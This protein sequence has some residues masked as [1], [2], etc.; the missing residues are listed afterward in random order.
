MRRALLRRFCKDG[1]VAAAGR[2]KVELRAAHAIGIVK[3]RRA[4][5]DR[6]CGSVRGAVG[7]VFGLHARRAADERTHSTGHVAGFELA[8]RR[9]RQLRELRAAFC[10]ALGGVA[11]A[12]PRSNEWRDGSFRGLFGMFA[13][14]AKHEGGK[15]RGQDSAMSVYHD[16][17]IPRLVGLPAD[18]VEKDTATGSGPGNLGF[19]SRRRCGAAESGRDAGAAGRCRVHQRA[20]AAHRRTTARTGPR[21]ERV[22][23]AHGGPATRERRG[24]GRART[25][26]GR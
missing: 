23:G 17:I 20:R 24:T 15:K 21:G 16:G 19:A 18:V 9:K 7:I 10:G 5:G 8:V 26:A 14:R 4:F 25:A 1:G 22:L 2:R 3:A 13:A 6:K 12:R 11:V